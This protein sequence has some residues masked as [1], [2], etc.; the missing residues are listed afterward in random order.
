MAGRARERDQRQ[1][2]VGHALEG[3]D[4]DPAVAGLEPF[5][6]LGRGC[7]LRQQFA[8]VLEDDGAE[9]CDPYRSGPTRMVEH[10][11]ADGSLQC[12]DL[13]AHG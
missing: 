4:V 1:D 10:R 11:A 13:L 7:S 9:R 3:A 12:G 6:G 5:H 8:S 2:H